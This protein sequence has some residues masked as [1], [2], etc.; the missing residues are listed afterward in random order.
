MGDGRRERKKARGKEEDVDLTHSGPKARRIH[1]T[2]PT[3]LKNY[4]LVKVPQISK[5]MVLHQTWPKKVQ[6]VSEMHN[7]T[8]GLLLG[9]LPPP[10]P[11]GH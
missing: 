4:F 5:Q 7:C 9:L 6:M 2:P 3:E 8:A 1:I 10:S 11:P